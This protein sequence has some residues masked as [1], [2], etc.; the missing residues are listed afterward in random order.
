MPLSRL[1]AAAPAG[2][3]GAGPPPLWP[4][5]VIPLS[6]L[7]AACP[8]AFWFPLPPAGGVTVPPSVCASA[9]WGAAA[10]IT[11]MT[12]AIAQS[13][14]IHLLKRKTPHPR[15]VSPP[16]GINLASGHEAFYKLDN[17]QVDEIVPGGEHHQ[18]Q[19]Q[20]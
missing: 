8:A 9:A 14:Q 6:R 4:G 10:T 20:G 17:P 2:G 11:A 5:G 15:L 7:G 16:P 3:A 19:H 12:P 1:G 18:R 13:T